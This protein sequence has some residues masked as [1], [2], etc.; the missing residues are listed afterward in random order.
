MP[1]LVQVL[2]ASAVAVVV[3]MVGV[4]AISVAIKDAS[5]VDIAWGAGFVVVAWVAFFVGDG[6]P[7]RKALITG[8]T[9][10]WGV[11]LALHIGSRNAGK[12][13]D[14]RY[15][16]MRRAHP[17]NFPLW[18]LVN[19]Y[20]LQ[21]ALMFAVS[22]PVQMAQVSGGPDEL[23][24]LDYAGVALW[25]VGLFFET[26]GDAQLRRFKRNPANAG[27][28]MDQGLWRYT[29]HPNYFGDSVVWW[30]LFLV[31]L[32]RP[33]MAWTVVSPLIMTFLLTRVS[34]VPLLERSMA[35]RKPGYQEYMERTSAF[36]PRPPRR[37]R[38]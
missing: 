3:V 21:G 16:A 28:V 24:W 13:E 37:A 14:F 18:S 26:V 29:R 5:I 12:G 17:N 15:Q 20:G 34:G 7:E 35:R 10:A 30:G 36:F 6:L 25:V 19:V 23:T 31:A 22:L 11:R 9:S 2:V 38:T 8:M 4:W 32:A 33:E 1:D 27:K